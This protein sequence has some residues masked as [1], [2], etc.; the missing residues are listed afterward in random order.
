MG[1]YRRGNRWWMRWT[2]ENGTLQRKSSKSTSKDVAATMLA[3]EKMAVQRR[4]AGLPGA[5]P[6]AA[7]RPISEQVDAYLKQMEA[8]GLTTTHIG[9]HGS[10]L[11]RARE[12]CGWT[13]AQD[14][15]KASIERYLN[16]AMVERARKTRLEHYI[17][18]RQLCAFLM[19]MDPPALVFDPSA[20]AM[21]ALRGKARRV[22][23]SAEVKRRPLSAEECHA[24]L[25]APPPHR[26]PSV[27]RWEHR[28]RV[29]AF[30]IG[31][32]L[33]R[34]ELEGLRVRNV[35]LDTPMPF[36]TVP[37]ELSKSG[38]PRVLPIRPN[39]VPMMREW[40]RGLG[41]GVAFALPLPDVDTMHRDLRRAGV[42]FEDGSGRLTDLHALRG[43]CCTLLGLARI[44]TRVAQLFMGHESIETTERYYS[45][46]GINDLQALSADAPDVPGIEA[47]ARVAEVDVFG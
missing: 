41:P 23:R 13:C 34:A 28:K 17:A 29:Y 33:R 25:N 19:A 2:D 43:T 44:P 21:P 31:H 15:T 30:L 47:L 14:V 27:F 32:G 8:E 22:E 10:Y 18:I 40:T 45:M 46:V 26:C 9:N 37:G 35:R 24:L 6:V 42:A 39:L 20:G 11:R 4:R 7:T 3:A 36:L 12:F 16:V 38:R 5:S 1:L